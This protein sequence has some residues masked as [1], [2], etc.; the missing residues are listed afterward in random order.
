[1]N[2]LLAACTAIAVLAAVPALA[3]TK[4]HPAKE[5]KLDCKAEITSTGSSRPTLSLAHGSARATW[6]NEVKT[7]HGEQYQEVQYAKSVRYRCTESTLGL[8]RCTITAA[9]C[10]VPEEATATKK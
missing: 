10:R 4:K 8:Q 7:M 9:P 2:K 5:Q 1:M 6:K 3:E